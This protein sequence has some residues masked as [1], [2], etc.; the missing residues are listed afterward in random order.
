MM[1]EN[2]PSV[3]ESRKLS[4]LSSI[5]VLNSSRCFALLKVMLVPT[6]TPVVSV[7]Q[8]LVLNRGFSQAA[9]MSL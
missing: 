4:S 9:T 1:E 8:M 7:L 6:C 2:L 5:S 3:S